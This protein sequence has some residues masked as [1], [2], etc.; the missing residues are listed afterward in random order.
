MGT[1]FPLIPKE[2]PLVKTRYRTIQ[3]QIPVPASLPILQALQTYEPRS[4]TGQPLILW[5]RAEDVS[6]YDRWGNKW[7]DWSSGVLVT[8]AGHGVPEIRDA[9]KWA[10]DKP[11]LHHYCFP[12][13]SRLALVQKLVEIAPDELNKVFLLTTGSEATENAIKI[14][15]TYGQRTGG[16]EKIGIVTFTHAFHGRTLGAQQ[17]G[18]IPGLKQWIGHLDPYFYQ[19]DFPDGFRCPDTSFEYFLKTLKERRVAPNSIAAVMTETYQGGGAS[20]A[21]KEYMQSLAQWCSE[22][23]VLLIL[24]EIQAAFGRTGT[25]FGFEQY[26]VVPDIICLGKGISSS[27]PLSAVMGKDELLDMFEPGEM[28][29]THSGNP[30][31]TSAALANINFILDNNLIENCRS[32]G[33]IL[34]AG[35]MNLQKRF[36]NRIGAVHGKGLVAGVHCTHKNSTEPDGALAMNVVARCVEKGLLMFAPV[37]Y[38]GATIKISPPLIISEPAV[39]EGLEAFEEAMS[40]VIQ[41][42]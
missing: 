15:R 5:D 31:C 37:G 22:N 9:V 21:P 16:P 3:T 32:V 41:E 10:V 40:E 18:G 13:E 23:N 1:P 30:L 2:V 42:K 12:G 20:F 33:N 28:T 6:V 7:L 34:H 25:F 27:L 19:V 24:D 29:S 26:D 36:A 39:N 35:L 8:N 14:A 38:G 11:L 17:L 4:M